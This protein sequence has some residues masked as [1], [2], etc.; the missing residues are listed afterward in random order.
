MGERFKQCL[1]NALNDDVPA[2]WL[3]YSYTGDF[4]RL[5]KEIESGT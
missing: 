5:I 3:I 1:E 4:E 2:N